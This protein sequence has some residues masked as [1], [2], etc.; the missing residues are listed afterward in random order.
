MR[1][2]DH[3][4]RKERFLVAREAIEIVLLHLD[5][6]GPTDETEQLRGEVE[7]L[8]CETETWRG[9]PPTDRDRDGL[10]K[11]VLA[12]YVDVMELERETPL[13]RANGLFEAFGRPMSRSPAIR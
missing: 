12:L 11:R 7:E 9:S 10:M 1:R 5:C 13:A 4:I 8:L 3:M 6:L 2:R